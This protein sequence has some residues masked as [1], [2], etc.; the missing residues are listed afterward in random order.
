MSVKGHPDTVRLERLEW[1]PVLEKVGTGETEHPAGVPMTGHHSQTAENVAVF[2]V[3]G[4]EC[5]GKSRSTGFPSPKT[6]D[7]KQQ[8][9]KGTQ[10]YKT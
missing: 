1:F 9:H 4:Q 3:G 7:G 5:C 2:L 8:A 6:D 10:K